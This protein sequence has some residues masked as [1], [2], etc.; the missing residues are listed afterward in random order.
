[1]VRERIKFIIRVSWLCRLLHSLGWSLATLAGWPY[2]VQ[3]M[4]WFGDDN[5]VGYF[6]R[7]KRIVE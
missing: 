6:T 7:L 1:M 5:G 2:S 4:V 3:S